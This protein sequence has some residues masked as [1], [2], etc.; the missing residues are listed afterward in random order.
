MEQRVVQG[1]PVLNALVEGREGW[2][3]YTLQDRNHDRG[4]R[5]TGDVPRSHQY[6]WTLVGLS[7][8]FIFSQVFVLEFLAQVTINAQ[9]NHATDEDRTR[10][11]QGEI[12][13]D[14]KRERRN[15]AHLEHDCDHHAQQ[16]ER[17]GKLTIQNSLDDIRHQG[18]FWRVIL[19][20]GRAIWSDPMDAVDAWVSQVDHSA[21]VIHQVT[22]SRTTL[23]VGLVPGPVHAAIRVRL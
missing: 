2:P 6:A 9:A 15:S 17:P 8:K 20:D 12:N 23:G 13:A 10:G 1:G 5:A 19:G 4:K 14:R 3:R 21:L 7:H 18:R 22:P 16:H 11:R